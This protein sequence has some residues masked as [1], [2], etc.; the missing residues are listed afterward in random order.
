[1]KRRHTGDCYS[2]NEL[3]HFSEPLQGSVKDEMVLQAVGKQTYSLFCNALRL[4][5]FLSEDLWSLSRVPQTLVA[6]GSS[7]K[8]GKLPIFCVL[9]QVYSVYLPVYVGFDKKSIIMSCIKCIRNLTSGC[10]QL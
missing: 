5:I 9:A 4:I 2:L 3:S 7:D 8:S 6:Q 1:M 10:H